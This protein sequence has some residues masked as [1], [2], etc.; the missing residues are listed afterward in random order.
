MPALN[1]VVI[2]QLGMGQSAVALLDDRMVLPVAVS[3]H[4]YQT[5]MGW[6]CESLS[7]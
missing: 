3:M 6:L 4:L 2:L 7:K 5:G 1:A